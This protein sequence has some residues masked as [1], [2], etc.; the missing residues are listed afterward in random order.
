MIDAIVQRQHKSAI[1]NFC[2][3][4]EILGGQLSSIDNVPIRALVLRPDSLDGFFG[5]EGRRPTKKE[6]EGKESRL[7]RFEHSFKKPWL[8]M[9]RGAVWQLQPKI[10]YRRC[11]NMSRM[12]FS[13]YLGHVT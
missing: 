1:C 3:Q 13:G 10:V 2:R 5:G 6:S 11:N 12:N 8:G 4:L 7:C 9:S